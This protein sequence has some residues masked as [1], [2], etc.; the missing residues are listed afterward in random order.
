MQPTGSYN[1]AECQDE[2]M[3][4]IRCCYSDK[5]GVFCRWN[6]CELVSLQSWMWSLGIRTS[7]GVKGNDACKND[8]LLWLKSS[9]SIIQLKELC[10]RFRTSSVHQFN[11]IKSVADLKTDICQKENRSQWS[12]SAQNG[13]SWGRWVNPLIE[14]IEQGSTN[15]WAK[16][17]SDDLQNFRNPVRHTSKNKIENNGEQRNC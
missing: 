14:L 8:R 13:H 7:L 9:R 11:S 6:A 15:D 5:V 16:E 2:L 12:C 4:G 3:E 17:N 1:F 10:M